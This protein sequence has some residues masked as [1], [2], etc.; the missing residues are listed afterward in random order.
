MKDLL[1][2]L[3]EVLPLAQKYVLAWAKAL[4]GWVVSFIVLK[5]TNVGAEVD[6]DVV[7]NLEAGLYGLIVAVWVWLVPN[8]Q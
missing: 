3:K 4:V 2:K 7:G 6:E 1:K 8:K 5:L